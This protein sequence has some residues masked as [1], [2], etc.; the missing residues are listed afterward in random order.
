MK[1]ALLSLL[2]LVS[3]SCIA[4]KSDSTGKKKDTTVIVSGSNQYMPL[5]LNFNPNQA[6]VLRDLLNMAE[7]SPILHDPKIF[8]L[9]AQQNIYYEF[10]EG[11][12][13]VL[14]D[15]LSKWD[16]QRKLDSAK[17]AQLIEPVKKKK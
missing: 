5:M 1:K 6:L 16:N 2:L 7:Q 17:S 9:T 11:L 10:A 3:I 8:P 15:Q 4:Q 13:Q 14:N 12:Q